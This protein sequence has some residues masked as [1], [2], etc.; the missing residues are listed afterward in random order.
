MHDCQKG[1]T[2]MYLSKSPR[3]KK[4]IPT[5]I[6]FKIFYLKKTFLNCDSEIHIIGHQKSASWR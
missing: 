4:K 2:A 6:K 1:A 3:R 5:K